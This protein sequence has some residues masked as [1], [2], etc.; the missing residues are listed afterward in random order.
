LTQA[1]ETRARSYVGVGVDVG[2]AA[3]FADARGRSVAGALVFTGFCDCR[4]DR[5]D[6]PAA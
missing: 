2:L 4:A 6:F 3:A 5:G 1:L